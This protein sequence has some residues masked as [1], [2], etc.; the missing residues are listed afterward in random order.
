MDFLLKIV[1]YALLAITTLISVFYFGATLL[2]LIDPTHT[3]KR[4]DD[5]FMLAA[6]AVSL[7]ILYKAYLVGHEQG[8]WGTGIWLVLGAALSFLVIFLG[9]M[10]F[11]GK[12]HWQ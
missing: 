10:L 1:Y 6:T 12:I 8:N 3:G 2:G 4:Q 11:F 7:G 9:G 5:F